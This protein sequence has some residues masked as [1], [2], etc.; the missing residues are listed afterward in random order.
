MEDVRPFEVECD[1][2]G[3]KL[4]GRMRRSQVG[5]M[6]VVQERHQDGS[7]RRC[8]G[9]GRSLGTWPLRVELSQTGQGFEIRIG[10][11]RARVHPSRESLVAVL[12]GLGVERDE[13]QRHVGAI[14]PGPA[15]SIEVHERRKVPRG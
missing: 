3:R 11:G 4:T 5:Q 9:S 7:G 13:A 12:S 6:V 14:A 15:I 10:E 1:W 8:L 2:C